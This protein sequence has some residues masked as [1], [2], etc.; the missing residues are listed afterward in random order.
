MIKKYD[1]YLYIDRIH[2]PVYTL[3]PGK[4]IGIWFSGCSKKCYGCISP[5]LQ[6]RNNKCKKVSKII[7]I[8][9][10]IFISD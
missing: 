2:Y 1:A 9:K 6:K 5:S 3:G 4:R 10:I 8:I 7:E